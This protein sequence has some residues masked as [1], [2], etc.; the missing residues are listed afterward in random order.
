MC[1]VNDNIQN[2][3]DFYRQFTGKQLEI[4]QALPELTKQLPVMI[5][6]AYS[7]YVAE[8][9]G[10][11]VIFLEVKNPGNV[12]PLQLQKHQ[13]L[14]MAKTAIPVVF[15]LE[16]IASYNLSRL[17]TARVNFIVPGKQIFVPT[18]MMNMKEVKDGRVLEEE[19]MPGMAQC[20]LLYHIE[21]GGL[22]GKST[23]ELA[24]QFHVSYPNISR[25]LRWL[26]KKGLCRLN[27][28]K[29]KSLA[30][31]EDMKSL[32]EKALPLMPSPVERIVYTDVY[33]ENSKLAGESAMEELT[34]LAGPQIPV[35]AISKAEAKVQKNLLFRHEGK[36]V[37]EIWRYDPHFLTTRTAVDPL[38]LYLSMKASDDERV[39]IESD[40]LVNFIK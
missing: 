2:A 39:R 8:I 13:K 23:S 14:V 32:W 20:I 27:G 12:T 9:M 1:N 35:I 7:I 10:M 22:A 30:F 40:K 28:T 34:M 31:E 11:P 38:S 25:A 29:T 3:V 18:L 6:V 33:L 36:Y 4:K 15:V 37:V 5:T 24:E 21:Q 19:I 17:A 26:E 16:R